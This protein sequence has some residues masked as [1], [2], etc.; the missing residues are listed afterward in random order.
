MAKRVKG[1]AAVER[2]KLQQLRVEYAPIDWPRPNEYN[3]NRQ[4]KHEFS[5]LLRSI[6]EDGMTQPIICLPDGRIVDGE[7]RWRACQELGHERVP[8]VKVDMTEE[9]RRV[10]TLRHNLARGSHDIELEAGVLKDLE[11]LGA[12]DWA[13]EALQL[14]DVEMNRLLEDLTPLDEWGGGEWNQAWDYSPVG[15]LTGDDASQS[16]QSIASLPSNPAERRRELQQRGM[17]EA[18]AE[19][20]KRN[21]TFTAAQEEVVKQAI[22]EKPADT[23]LAMAEAHVDAK[24]RSGRGQWTTLTFTVPTQ[25]LLVIE[26][27][28]DRLSAHA[29]NRNPDLTPELQRGLALEYMAVLSGQ[30]PRE[31]LA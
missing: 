12:K 31:S 2:I 9:Q 20:V 18:D 30:T 25:A 24:E 23:L 19:L 22:G 26:Q 13:R 28:L 11:A 7:H 27:E 15:S 4:S 5:L 10:A 6:G 16:A 1:Q 17:A 29:P 3:P 21:F 8:V 14:S